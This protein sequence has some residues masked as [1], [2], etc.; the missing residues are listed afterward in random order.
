MALSEDQSDNDIGEKDDASAATATHFTETTA[1]MPSPLFAGAT[2]PTH[3]PT[4]APT[5]GPTDAPNPQPTDAP[6]SPPQPTNAP[7]PNAPWSV[8]SGP[9]TV[10]RQQWLRPQPRI[11]R[12]FESSRA[13]WQ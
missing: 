11:R 8:Q 9:C 12:R 3:A 4:T 10:C 5:P 7:N 6:T 1:N 2:G 13:V